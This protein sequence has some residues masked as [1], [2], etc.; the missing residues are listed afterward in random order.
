MNL[1]L[2][3]WKGLVLYRI[4]G[5]GE[6]WFHIVSSFNA[7]T[8]PPANNSCNYP[9]WWP[10]DLPFPHPYFHHQI[11]PSRSSMK[12]KVKMINLRVKC[13][14]SKIDGSVRHQS[15]NSKDEAVRI[16]AFQVSHNLAGK[17]GGRVRGWHNAGW[18]DLGNH[19]SQEIKVILTHSA[20]SESRPW[21]KGQPCNLEESSQK[22]ILLILSSK[23]PRFDSYF[24]LSWKQTKLKTLILF[25]TMLIAFP[26]ES[27]ICLSAEIPGLIPRNA[28]HF[29]PTTSYGQWAGLKG[30]LPTEGPSFWIWQAGALNVEDGK[31]ER[32]WMVTPGKQEVQSD[33]RVCIYYCRL[34]PVETSH[35][36]SMCLGSLC[37]PPADKQ[38]CHVAPIPRSCPGLLSVGSAL[39][40]LYQDLPGPYYHSSVLSPTASVLKCLFKGQ[41]THFNPTESTFLM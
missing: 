3:S 13:P 37:S 4:W 28:I 30:Q 29:S 23:C 31:K 22:D 14:F 38:S 9:G 1:S 41:N 19:R 34:G 18:M 36:Q 35:S 11:L 5:E 15:L 40:L 32:L 25:Q 21:F 8:P 20:Y 10:Q 6:A 27:F 17:W 24:K 2:T 7:P 16:I 26:F 12:I 39:N 33:G